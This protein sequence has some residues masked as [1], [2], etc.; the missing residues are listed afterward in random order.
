MDLRF[1][2][3]EGEGSN[4]SVSNYLVWDGGHW[5]DS[6]S[7][8]RVDPTLNGYLDKS[9]ED[10]QEGCAKA[11]DGWPPTPMALPG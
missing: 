11:Q 6:V 4:L 3:R 1:F 9:G 2:V 5:R 7:S 10:K 8:A